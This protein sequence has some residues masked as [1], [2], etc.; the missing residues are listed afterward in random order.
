MRKIEEKDSGII[1]GSLYGTTAA[2]ALCLVLIF[3]SAH[4]QL[5]G[6]IGKGSIDVGVVVVLL[7]SSVLGNWISIKRT[8]RNKLSVSIVTTATILCI[9]LISGLAIDGEFKSVLLHL[10]VVIAGWLISCLLCLNQTSN[11][12]RKKRR[13]R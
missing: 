11:S 10:G 8:Q 4:L 3:W 2:V 9:M 13:Y 1:L 7:L 6:K 12:R 5:Q